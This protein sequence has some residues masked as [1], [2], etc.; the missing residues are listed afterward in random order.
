[1]LADF[2]D[3]F[4]DGELLALSAAFLPSFYS[5]TSWAMLR[6]TLFVSKA[7]WPA[8]NRSLASLS[9]TYVIQSA[10]TYGVYWVWPIDDLR[11]TIHS[12]ALINIRRSSLQP[13]GKGS[14]G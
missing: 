13:P 12:Y 1:M 8:D 9:S 7:Y 11:Y 6:R 14:R 5:M 2:E 3:S 4:N 10:R